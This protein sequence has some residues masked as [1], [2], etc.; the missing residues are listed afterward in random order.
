MATRTTVNDGNWDDPTVWD[1]AVPANSDTAVI[2]TEDE[3]NFN[4]DQS[5]F[6]NGLSGITLDG[7]LG[8][9][10]D[11]DTCLKMNGNLSGDGDLHVGTEANPIARPD[12]GKEYRA[13][14]LFNS[15]GIIN[16][17]NINMFG[18]YPSRE[19]T[20]LAEDAI[21]GQNQI[22]LVHD[23]GFQA[24]DIILIGSGTEDGMTAES[25]KGIYTVNSYDSET[26]IVTLTGNL[27]T[28]RR[29]VD[30]VAQY[31]RPIKMMRSSG[32]TPFIQGLDTNTLIIGLRFESGHLISNP[33]YNTNLTKGGIVKHSSSSRAFIQYAQE[34]Y[35]EECVGTVYSLCSFMFEG[36]IKKCIGIHSNGILGYTLGNIDIEDCI[37]QN[38]TYPCSGAGNNRAVFPNLLAKNTKLSH[39]YGNAIY[40]NGDIEISGTPLSSDLGGNAL[41]NNVTCI[42]TTLRGEGLFNFGC[43]KCY[44]CIFVNEPGTNF[45]KHNG[46]WVESFDHN[47]VPGNYKAWMRG[48]KIETDLD[49]STILPGRL[50]LSCESA[51]YPVFRDF[52]VLLP[53]YRTSTWQALTKKDFTGGSVKIELIDP[54]NDP[55]I[56]PSA[57]PLATYSLPDQADTNLPLKLG[58]KSTVAMQAIIRISAQNASGTVEVDTRLIENRVQHGQ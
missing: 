57:Q 21:A 1:G 12:N 39:G 52:P 11:V 16:V 50:I 37:I 55:L 6:A 3:I 27:Q 49:G 23:M 45:T 58:Y 13:Y 10:K 28:N 9:A 33:S 31:S 4:T 43:G 24:G 15:T 32:S 47:Q 56:D 44:N 53:A 48:G 46:L 14:L 30:I 20:Q 26:K 40:K 2:R 42:N 8:W 7:Y 19:Y 34:A 29:N 35:L 51:D 17:P 38:N 22:K 41:N 18:W 36:N 54:A 25:N 5:G